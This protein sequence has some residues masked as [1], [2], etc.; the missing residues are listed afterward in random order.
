MHK[1]LFYCTIAK[2]TQP[3]VEIKAPGEAN[4]KNNECEINRRREVAEREREKCIIKLL[5][6]AFALGF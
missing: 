5:S 1:T 6:R 3:D 4:D 2:N